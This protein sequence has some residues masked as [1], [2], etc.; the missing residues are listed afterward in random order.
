MPSNITSKNVS[1]FT[2]AGPP[3]KL[4]VQKPHFLINNNHHICMPEKQTKQKCYAI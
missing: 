1:G 4:L 2:L 3:C